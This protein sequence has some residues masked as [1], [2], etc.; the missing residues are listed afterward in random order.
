[1]T[2]TEHALSGKYYRMTWG[3]PA[4]HAAG[5]PREGSAEPVTRAERP[6]RLH[7][8]P[9]PVQDRPSGHRQRKGWAP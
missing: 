2:A 1:M 5:A 9:P 3:P 4:P 6:Y 7:L 8:G